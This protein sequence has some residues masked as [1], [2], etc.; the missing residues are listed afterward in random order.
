MSEAK[1]R[2]I[3]KLCRHFG[4]SFEKRK[5]ICYIANHL[6]RQRQV[7]LTAQELRKAIRSF[8]IPPDKP[9]RTVKHTN[10]EGPIVFENESRAYRIGVWDQ[11][12]TI[13][14]YTQDSFTL[15]WD[16]WGE[17]T[18]QKKGNDLWYYVELKDKK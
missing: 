1:D 8:C 10:W 4:I 11:E 18:F 17:E 5:D 7:F 16:K 2:V 9:V 15:K 3:N 13:V 12:A 14:E 6:Q